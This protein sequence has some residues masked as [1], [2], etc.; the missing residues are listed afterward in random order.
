MPLSVATISCL[1]G[2]VFAALISWLVEQQHQLIQQHLQ[3]ILGEPV[4]QLLDR[5]ISFY[6]AHLLKTHREQHIHHAKVAFLP[7]FYWQCTIQGG[8]LAPNDWLL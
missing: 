2:K 5:L 4:L 1:F 8:D 6:A 7:L 3:E